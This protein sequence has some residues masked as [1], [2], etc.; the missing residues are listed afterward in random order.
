MTVEPLDG[1]YGCWG[2]SLSPGADSWM[3]FSPGYRTWIQAIPGADWCY[4]GGV[5][6]SGGVSPSLLQVV[7][8]FRVPL[9]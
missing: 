6:S 1:N 3:V 7:G 2:S 8:C 9:C 4:S 5:V